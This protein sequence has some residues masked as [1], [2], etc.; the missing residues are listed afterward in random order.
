MTQSLL[1]FSP[2]QPVSI[3]EEF[4][5]LEPGILKSVHDPF[6]LV[7]NDLANIWGIPV[8]NF[9]AAGRGRQ[10]VANVRMIGMATCYRWDAGV[11]EE[12]ASAFNRTD[13]CTVLHAVRSLDTI[14]TSSEAYRA[15]YLLFLHEVSNSCTALQR[16]GLA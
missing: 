14:V 9:S 11:L 12:V 2:V 1:Q 3:Q 10:H 16:T 13:H 8:R 6:S 5:I 4:R 15:R 7:K